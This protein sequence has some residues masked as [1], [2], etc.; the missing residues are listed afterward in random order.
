MHDFASFAESLKMSDE[1]APD[2]LAENDRE[3]LRLTATVLAITSDPDDVQRLLESVFKAGVRAG[4]IAMQQSTLVFVEQ[5]IAL[6]E[7]GR[8]D[9]AAYFE[10]DDDA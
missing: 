2:R 9:A 6:D 4:Q 1:L 3:L 10:G 7:A 5:L 8:A